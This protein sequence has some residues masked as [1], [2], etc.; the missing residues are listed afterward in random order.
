MKQN[1][2]EIAQIGHTFKGLKK[3]YFK[4]KKSFLDYDVLFI[5]LNHIGAEYDN[6]D[7]AKLNYHDTIFVNSQFR[8]DYHRRMKD[9][10]NFL[11]H[12]K[13][14]FV[15]NF[16]PQVYKTESIFLNMPRLL[17]NDFIPIHSEGK[18]VDIVANNKNELS[19]FN[20]YKNHLTYRSYFEDVE[21]NKLI[22][23]QG[24]NKTVSFKNGNVIYLPGFSDLDPTDEQSFIDD[25]IRTFIQ[26]NSDLSKQMPEW[27]K[28]YILPNENKKKADLKKLLENQEMLKKSIDDLELEIQLIENLKIL[29]TGTGSDLEVKVEEIFKELGF[30]ILPK[31]ANRDDIIAKYGGNIFV[32]EIKGV[33]GSAAEKQAAQLEKWVAE[34]KE[35]NEISPKG[36]LIVNSFKD[37]EL[38]DRDFIAFFPNQMIPY[39][40]NRDHCLIS[41]I[42]LL[43]LFLDYKNDIHKRE[44]LIESLLK[45]KG[46]YQNYKNWNEF[47]SQ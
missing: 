34:Y 42:Q 46:V 21:L 37:T 41:G 44:S 9:I 38:K 47:I 30:E 22:N 5:N 45:T 25:I 29:F 10:E 28:E 18:R 7:L 1:K 12:D 2:L 16:I 6:N 24:S 3:V 32:I 39:S 19:F 4:S 17:P 14:I 11:E 27:S 33:K 13:Y 43:G 15:L 26:N 35:H 23:V 40:S 20:K 31:K 36:I 8:D